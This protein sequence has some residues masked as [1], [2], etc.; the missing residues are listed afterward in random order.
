MIYIPFILLIISG[1][2][3]PLP[4]RSEVISTTTLSEI[5]ESEASGISNVLFLPGIKGSR[6]YE[7]DEKLWEPWGNAEVKA[8]FLNENGQ[9]IRPDV[10]AKAGDI[11]S[12]SFGHQ[13]YAS[14]LNDLQSYKQEGIFGEQWTWETA[15]YDWR[16][17]LPDIVTLGAREDDRLFYNRVVEMPYI[18][19][20]L[21]DLA[22]SSAT[23]KVTIVAHS[24]GGLVAKALMQRLGDQATDLVDDIIFVGVPHTGAPRAFAAALF[25]YGE[26]LPFDSCSEWI[27]AR[28][29]CALLVDRPTAR[30][31]AEFSPMT[32]HLL[33]SDAYLNAAHN[34]GYPVAGWYGLTLFPKERERYGVALGSWSELYDYA[35]ALENGRSKPLPDDTTRPNI[36]SQSL[37][38]YAH[39]IHSVLDTWTP[40]IGIST[41]TIVGW[42][43]ETLSGIQFYEKPSAVSIWGGVE[44]MYR[45][46]FF[47][48]GDGIVPTKSATLLGND[49]YEVNLSKERAGHADLLEIPRVRERIR[50]ILTKDTATF[51]TAEAEPPRERSRRIIFYV[52]EDAT[53]G[54]YDEQGNYAG[55]RDGHI[56]LDAPGVEYGEL[57]EVKYMLVPAN[58]PYELVIHGTAHGSFTF[59]MLERFGN[60]VATTSSIVDVPVTPEAIAT[61][62]VPASTGDITDLLLDY[63]G[64]GTTD[65]SI[66]PRLGR[67]TLVTEVPVI[68]KPAPPP[69]SSDIPT[70]RTQAAHVP[71]PSFPT[72]V[73]ED[74]VATSTQHLEEDN[75]P[76]D[77]S[78]EDM[79]PPT[80]TPQPEQRTQTASVH[81][82][83]T[84]VAWKSLLIPIALLALLLLL[85]STRSYA[86]MRKRKM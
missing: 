40:P 33:P 58:H 25:G 14:F 77:D 36:L 20:L 54:L 71:E 55:E 51:R 83:F 42:G 73:T 66:T 76:P 30:Q 11:L 50:K 49:T 48:D 60:D 22:G 19:R 5:P 18:E 16:L 67:P 72:V 86:P 65:L 15:A 24:N 47:E 84:G 26:A 4:A 27:G 59:E 52:H 62:T 41:H 70:K 6:L 63:D 75:Q 21:R 29:L 80:V 78:E 34:D 56:V 7:H 35:L 45:P 81:D 43:K 53:L 61:L 39:D 3:S 23:G 38:E 37:M 10:Y 82:A 2:L 44:A 13:F 69:E 85:L 74:T 9:S 46:I 1:L 68:P 32:Y 17:S 28:L 8:L 57:G 79:P 31:F 12:E 64:N